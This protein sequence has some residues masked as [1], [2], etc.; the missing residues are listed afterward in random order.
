M[1][2]AIEIGI[3][4]YN[5]HWMPGGAVLPDTFRK[6]KDFEHVVAIK[7]SPPEGVD[8]EDIFSL[9]D[10]FN[11]IDNTKNAVR[12]YRLGGHGFISV[13]I[14]V[15]PPHYIGVWDLMEAGRYDDAQAQWD[16]IEPPMR[17]FYDKLVAI[18]GGQARMKKAMLQLRGYPVGASRPPSLPVNEKELAELRVLMAGWG[19]PVA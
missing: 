1:S 15:Y 7:W 13:G 17:A 6:M 3:P 12:C 4:V 11:I 10:S 8:Y 19:W 16:R 2:N 14:E 5:T 18:S 9:T